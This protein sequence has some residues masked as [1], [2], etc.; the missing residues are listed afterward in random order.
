MYADCKS[1]TNYNI[2]SFNR[3]R[4]NNEKREITIRRFN[5]LLFNTNVIV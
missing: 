3:I 2:C 5:D 4:L 1:R